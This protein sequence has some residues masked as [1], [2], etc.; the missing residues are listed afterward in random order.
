MA[1]TSNKDSSFDSRAV[2]RRILW[3]LPISV[4]V[5]VVIVLITTDARDLLR[6][7][8][9]TLGFLLLAASLRLVPWITKTLRLMNWMHFLNHPFTFRQGIRITVMS[10]LGA[11]VSPT[12]IGGEPVKAG[13]LY[14]RGV[15]FG[16]STSLTTIAAVEDLS[17]YLVG[18]PIALIFASAFQVGQLGHVVAEDMFSQWWVYA[19]LGAIVVVLLGAGI[20]IRRS[21]A[22]PKFRQRVKRFWS[23]FKRLYE[24]LI[25]RGKGR[26]ALNVL[27][28]A[29]HWIARY[30][31]VAALATSLGY[32]VNIVGVIIL[33]WLVFAVMSFIPTPG[34]TGGA[35]GIFLL[36][37]STVLPQ[38]AIGTILIGWR[39]LDYYFVVMLALVVL[40][41]EQ[42]LRRIFPGWNT[43][44]DEEPREELPGREASGS[45]EEGEAKQDLTI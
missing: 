30:S 32:E 21:H 37:F 13:M 15:S 38:S 31:V 12:L 22:M 42:L 10:E 18:M 19:I 34:A 33:Q 11:A 23:E 7:E 29:A 45:A 24:E 43:A 6:L 40:T 39:F 44:A 41:G 14:G 2:V 9:F 35:E 16:E 25:K 26:F 28:A 27:L 36:L 8:E 5:S 1:A 20:V 17:F 4:A 3:V